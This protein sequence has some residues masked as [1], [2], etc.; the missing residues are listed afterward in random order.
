MPVPNSDRGVVL[1]SGYPGFD[2]GQPPGEI[3]RIEAELFVTGIQSRFVGNDPHLNQVDWLAAGCFA[4][5]LRIPNPGT[6]CHPLRQIGSNGPA[7]TLGILVD[8]SSSEHPGDNLHVLVR[9]RVEPGACFDRAAVMTAPL[10]RHSR[11]ARRR[12]ASLAGHPIYMTPPRAVL[13]SAR[14]GLSAEVHPP[15][16]RWRRIPPSLDP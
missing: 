9:Q 15:G 3:G 16:S 12:E 14:P 8:E 11:P 7:V 13:R 10:S 4:V 2:D 6:R 5:A 1:V